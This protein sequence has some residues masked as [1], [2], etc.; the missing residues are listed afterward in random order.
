MTVRL[1]RETLP[2]VLYVTGYVR[3]QRVNRDGVQVVV[4]VI[5][6]A[7]QGILFVPVEI[8]EVKSDTKGCDQP[9]IV[10]QTSTLF[11]QR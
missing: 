6:R 2:V 11:G 9:G 8:G 5:E 7:E 3:P 1:Y 4:D 10:L